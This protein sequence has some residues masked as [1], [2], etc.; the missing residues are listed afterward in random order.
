MAVLLKDLSSVCYNMIMILPIVK[1]PNKVLSTPS[2]P[3]KQF[4]EKLK[5]LV[6][7]MGDTLIAA[8]DPEGVGLAAPQ[9]G[10]GL[11]LFVTRPDKRAKVREYIN[12][13]LLKIVDIEVEKKDGKT[14]LEGCLSVDRI[15]SPIERPQKVLLSYQTLDGAKH[16]DWFEGFKAVIMQHEVD[17]LNGILFTARAMEQQ[18]T[19]YE[20]RNGELHE[21]SV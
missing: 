8:K 5:K 9:I 16:E 14:T 6:K 7:D 20:E 13:K 17:H 4:D 11:S 1:V 18:S 10:V 19:L 12:P 3:V 21:M 15:W 2:K